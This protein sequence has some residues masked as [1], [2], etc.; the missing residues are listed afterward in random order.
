[1]STSTASPTERLV[2]IPGSE[3]RVPPMAVGTMG[4]G[5]TVP[6]ETAHRLLD[7]AYAL[8]ARFW[9]TANNYAFWAPGGQ[10]GESEA[11]LGAW[12]VSRGSAAREEVVLAS[13]VGAQPAS[14]GGGLDDAL[15]LSAPAVVAQVEAS[16]RRLRVDAL[17]MV[18]A[19]VDD[20][21]V[22]L[23]ETVGALQ[24]LV[25]RGL[26]KT[27]AGSNLSALRLQAALEVAG[28]GPRYAALQDR[29]SYLLPRPGGDL[30][31]HVLLDEDLQQVCVDRDVLMLGYSPLLE[32]AY[33]RADRD[34]H[35][36]YGTRSDH[37]A[38]LQVLQRTSQD[39]GLDAGQG[40]LAWM[41]QRPAPVLPVVG[42]SRVEHVEQAWQAVHTPLA[43]D[44]VA[45]LEQAR[46]TAPP[47]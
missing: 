42:V 10:G 11:C 47:Q 41:T 18:Y 36:A 32:G 40:V 8:G 1:M 21:A 3:L 15:G 23:A 39:A 33:T 19:H 7:R 29:F 35:P 34:L 46:M 22:D 17:D 26:T 9:D 16:L 24:G 38:A 30:D 25:Q 14:P 28:D 44:A 2:Q 27:I 6:L 13:K 43:A 12:L 20:T 45:A 4:F 37:A 5:T 31:P